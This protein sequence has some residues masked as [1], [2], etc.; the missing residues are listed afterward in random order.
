MTKEQ[1]REIRLNIREPEFIQ[2]L[3]ALSTA[4]STELAVKVNQAWLDETSDAQLS[5]GLLT[6]RARLFRLQ[7]FLEA[8]AEGFPRIP[9]TWVKEAIEALASLQTMGE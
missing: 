4:N 7:G 2:L 1:E 6:I 8:E 9:L 3:E 5:E